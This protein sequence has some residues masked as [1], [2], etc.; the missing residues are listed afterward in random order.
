MKQ[1]V[2]G[3]EQ[4]LGPRIVAVLRRALHGDISTNDN[5]ALKC[6]VRRFLCR[7]GAE[8]ECQHIGRPLATEMSSVQLRH[9]ICIDHGYSQLALRYAC[10]FGNAFEVSG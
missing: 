2:H 4:Q 5:I 9:V 3:I 7:R 10:E 1:A 8:I 6:A